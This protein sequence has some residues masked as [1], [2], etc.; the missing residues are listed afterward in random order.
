MTEWKAAG[1]VF[2]VLIVI[3]IGFAIYLHREKHLTA[4][5]GRCKFDYAYRGSIDTLNESYQA[6]RRAFGKCLCELYL[7]KPDNT[8]G[9]LIVRQSQYGYPAPPD[10]THSP[11]Y[12]SLDTLIKYRKEVFD[13]VI[14]WD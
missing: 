3:G 9:R 7:T 6:D 14:L 2:S 12:K 8:L 5:Y 10:S 1:W 13:P 4:S 11:I